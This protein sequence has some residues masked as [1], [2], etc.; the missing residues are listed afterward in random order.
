MEVFI[1]SIQ[2]FIRK[3]SDYSP[4]REALS[5][6][7]ST[8]G[9]ELIL[10]T[11]YI[12][13]SLLNDFNSCDFID[14]IKSGFSINNIKRNDVKITIVGGMLKKKD[15][16]SNKYIYDIGNI[17]S[18]EVV[19]N[20][21]NNLFPVT[22]YRPLNNRWHGK[23]ALKIQNNTP[24][25]GLIGS[26]NLTQPCFGISNPSTGYQADINMESDLFIWNGRILKDFKGIQSKFLDVQSITAYKKLLLQP[27]LQK[28]PNYNKMHP[29]EKCFI[30][31]YCL[32]KSITADKLFEFFSKKIDFQNNQEFIDYLW[33]T[34]ISLSRCN[35]SLEKI[36]SGRI[37]FTDLLPMRASSISLEYI[38][39]D[40]LDEINLVKELSKRY[41]PTDM[42]KNWHIFNN[43]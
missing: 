16:T 13:Q 36:S 40:I 18:F 34:C 2:F 7:M 3:T 17:S 9:E 35:Q 6:L 43:K 23:I 12:S 14:S 19:I 21:L 8:P 25:I 11:G 33:I 27:L 30:R 24:V 15:I 4:F 22:Y 20:N 41:D 37:P 10:S 38:L 1:I 39:N 5:N 32:R 42:H 26:S 28:L 31:D 29:L